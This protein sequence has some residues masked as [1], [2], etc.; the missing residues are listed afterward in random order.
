MGNIS[1]KNRK[2]LEK[3]GIIPVIKYNN[4][5]TKKEK[6][7]K[8]LTEDEM[9]KYKKRVKIEHVFGNLKQKSILNV[10]EILIN[11][12]FQCN[13]KYFINY[14]NQVIVY[15]LLRIMKSIK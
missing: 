15:F 1:I 14:A 7:K 4:R 8:Y 10:R 13:D 3:H 12:V 9:K 11:I 6:N 2:I 5:R